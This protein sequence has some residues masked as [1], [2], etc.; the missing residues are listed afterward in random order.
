MPLWRHNFHTFP[1]LEKSGRNI[2]PK[3][4][5]ALKMYF[6]FSVWIA[7]A[8]RKSFVFF[9]IFLV[10]LQ[11]VHFIVFKLLSERTVGAEASLHFF[12][13]FHAVPENAI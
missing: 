12:G 3:P 10:G 1:A 9:C 7:Q 6:A 5:R 8:R 13:K 11:R 2:W 4:V